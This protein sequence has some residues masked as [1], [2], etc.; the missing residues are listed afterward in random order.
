MTRKTLIASCVSL[1]LALVDLVVMALPAGAANTTVGDWVFSGPYTFA[2]DANG[3]QCIDLWQDH[4][5]KVMA[6]TCNKSEAQQWYQVKPRESSNGYSPVFLAHGNP[7][8]GFTSMTCIVGT[9]SDNGPY[10]DF[11][12]TPLT[13][14]PCTDVGSGWWPVKKSA[15]HFK[16]VTYT[17]NSCIDD[18]GFK[19]NTQLY[20][21]NCNDG[22]NQYWH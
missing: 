2:S 15:G 20:T 11:Y 4:G 14:I 3:D 1:A 9:R 7:K 16:F 21:W 8:K 6:W 17:G 18:L 12:N 10:F 13:T 19:P 22:A 5:P